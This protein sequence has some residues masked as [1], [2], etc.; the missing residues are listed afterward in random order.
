MQIEL[1]H[2]LYPQ[3]SHNLVVETDKQI[4]QLQSYKNKN[5]GRL[6]VNIKKWS[7]FIMLIF[8]EWLVLTRENVMEGM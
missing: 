3:E 7:T 5:Q 4:L 1:S 8:E 2:N 6:I